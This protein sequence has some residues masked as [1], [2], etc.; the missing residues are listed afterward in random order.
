MH[1]PSLAVVNVPDSHRGKRVELSN[2]TRMPQP[3]TLLSDRQIVWEYDSQCGIH[4][5]VI[6]VVIADSDIVV[7]QPN[8]GQTFS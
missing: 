7:T 3:T 6:A 5:D 1:K 4:P 2:Q 8:I